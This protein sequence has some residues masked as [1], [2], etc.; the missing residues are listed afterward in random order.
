LR[1]ESTNKW[2]NKRLIKWEWKN[3][4]D[5]VIRAKDKLNALTYWD[6]ENENNRWIE[7][8]TYMNEK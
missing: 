7:E 1:S 5:W 3:A 8:M 2:K 6:A 4:K